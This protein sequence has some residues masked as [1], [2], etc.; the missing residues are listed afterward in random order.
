LVESTDL[1]GLRHADERTD[2]AERFTALH[3]T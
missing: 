2:C 1:T 3:R